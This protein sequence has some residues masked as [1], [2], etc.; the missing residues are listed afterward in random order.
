MNRRRDDT[1]PR[2]RHTVRDGRTR[3]SGRQKRTIL[4]RYFGAEAPPTQSELAKQYCVD[5]STIHR[6]VKVWESKVREYERAHHGEEVDYKALARVIVP[7]SG[8]SEQSGDKPRTRRRTKLTHELLELL[9]RRLP[10]RLR[11]LNRVKISKVYQEI[12]PDG[13]DRVD[14]V[15]RV[16]HSTF[17]KAV[18]QIKQSK[19]QQ[20]R[21]ECSAP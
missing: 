5:R 18:E 20:T 3:L 15:A 4:E 7:T 10:P 8:G 14:G 1:R 11:E 16:G 9:E 6:L 17:Y 12:F 21:T 13:V 2:T 19:R